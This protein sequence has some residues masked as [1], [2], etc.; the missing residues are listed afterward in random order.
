MKLEKK[1]YTNSTDLP[2]NYTED[3]FE[4]L[5]IEQK[6]LSKYTGGSVF[7]VYLK[8]RI[9]H[10]KQCMKLVNQ[11]ATHYNVS[12]F[13]ISPTYCVCSEHGY[14]AGDLRECP[15][16]GQKMEI[17]SRV[18]GYYQPVERWNEGKKEEFI[19][20]QNYEV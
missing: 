13:T 5:D 19:Q 11:I 16:C 6:F 8:K 17:W 2:V 12:C 15:V 1:Y 3:V 18:A 7:H 4:A 14:F 20:R 10:W 9:P